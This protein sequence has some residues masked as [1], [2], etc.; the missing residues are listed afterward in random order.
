[1]SGGS[2]EMIFQE[3]QVAF[4]HRSYKPVECTFFYERFGDLLRGNHKK[5]K[6]DFKFVSQIKEAIKENPQ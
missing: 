6:Y 1:M 3:M 2:R 4:G 5:E